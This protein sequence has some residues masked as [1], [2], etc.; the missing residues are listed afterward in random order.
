MRI[1]PE[2]EDEVREAIAAALAPNDGGRSGWADVAL[3]E[4]VEDAVPED[5]PAPL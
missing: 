3:R 1:E 2:P 4:S 5:G